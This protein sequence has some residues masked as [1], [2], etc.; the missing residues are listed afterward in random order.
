MKKLSLL[1]L[2]L[3]M[4]ASLGF[5]AEMASAQST[6]DI[7]KQRGHLRCQVGTPAPGF[8]QLDEKGDWYGSDVAICRAVAA[9]I[10][11]HPP[12]ATER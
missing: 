11:E 1:G 2:G 8:Y 3:G 9:A 4:M 10:R 6:L 7:V 12:I 5:T